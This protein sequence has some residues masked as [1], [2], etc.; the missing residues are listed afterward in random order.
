[1]TEYAL[2]DD[3][4]KVAIAFRQDG[5]EETYE[6]G[7]LAAPGTEPVWVEV[8]D[9]LPDDYLPDYPELLGPAVMDMEDDGK[10]HRYFPDYD[11]SVDRVRQVV[12]DRIDD[13][14]F[15]ALMDTDSLVV[16]EVETG[17][18]VPPQIAQ[19]RST[20]RNAARAAKERA[21]VMPKDKLPDFTWEVP[22]TRR[23]RRFDRIAPRAEPDPSTSHR[24][25]D[26][27]PTKAPGT[28]R[29]GEGVEVPEEER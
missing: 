28:V 20:A 9:E 5:S 19:Q 6:T 16:R 10:V 18:A 2:W 23:T 4:N 25:K 21:A 22:T 7:E 8:V 14:L 3:T 29:D 24:S 26:P 27:N 15:A 11:F 12:M 1:M 17:E 13:D